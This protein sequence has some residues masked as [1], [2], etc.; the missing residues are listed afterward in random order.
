M[1]GAGGGPEPCNIQ[2]G[3]AQNFMENTFEGSSQ[4]V[5]FMTVYFSLKVKKGSH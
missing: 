2:G 3:Y 4:T 5:K 1:S